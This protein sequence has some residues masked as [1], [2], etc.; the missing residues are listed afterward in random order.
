MIRHGV[1]V[2]V[3]L[4][5]GCHL[6]FDDPDPPPMDDPAP[7]PVPDPVPDLLDSG[8]GEGIIDI[9]FDSRTVQRGKLERIQLDE[10]GR[11]LSFEF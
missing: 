3:L 6:Y 10:T 1:V 11:L 2:A 8:D 7:A 9:H 4:L 5:G